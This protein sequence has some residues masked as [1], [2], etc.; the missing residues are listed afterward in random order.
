MTKIIAF[1]LLLSTLLFT[2]WRT[3]TE[4]KALVL[5][6]LTIIDINGGP[7]KPDMTVVITGNQITDLGEAGLSRVRSWRD[8]ACGWR[9]AEPRVTPT[10][11][12]Y[13]KKRLRS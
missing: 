2:G 1:L 6:R 5:M 10:L 13:F 4:Q 3:G 8:G 11:K 7:P 12:D 9:I